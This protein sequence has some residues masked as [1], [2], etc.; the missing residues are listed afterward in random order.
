MLIPRVLLTLELLDALAEEYSKI[1]TFL[2]PF[3]FIFILD[4]AHVMHNDNRRRGR[5]T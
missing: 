1:T 4:R 2:F 5:H 3:Y